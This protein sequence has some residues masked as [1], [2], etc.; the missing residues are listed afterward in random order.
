MSMSSWHAQVSDGHSAEQEKTELH[1]A[2]QSS[3][4]HVLVLKTHVII[5]DLHSS[6]PRTLPH[7]AHVRKAWVMKGAD[8]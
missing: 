3:S 8:M 1:A 6:G 4:F 5:S 2:Q 7:T